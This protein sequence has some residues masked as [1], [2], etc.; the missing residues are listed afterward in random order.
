T[1]AITAAWPSAIL[2]RMAA[3]KPRNPA[4]ASRS[5]STSSRRLAR[6][7]YFLAAVIS[8]A[9]TA[10]ILL[11]MSDIVFS[12]KGGSGLAQFLRH[13]HELLGLG[14]CGTGRNDGARLGHAIGD[15]GRDAGRIQRGAGIEYHDVARRAIGVV[16]RFENLGLRF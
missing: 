11:R 14:A 12:S 2:A 7:R 8:S 9:L 4:H 13:A 10:R 3:S 15:R 5:D 1:S 6:L 16:E